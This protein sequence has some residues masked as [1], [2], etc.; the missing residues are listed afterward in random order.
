MELAP[1]FHIHINYLFLNWKRK[2]DWHRIRIIGIGWIKKNHI[3]EAFCRAGIPAI[4]VHGYWLI[5]QR[6]L[7]L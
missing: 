1:F 7:F 5:P 2:W 6:P 4:G 3:L